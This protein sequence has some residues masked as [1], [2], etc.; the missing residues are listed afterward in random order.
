MDMRIPPLII[1]ILLESNPEVQNLS[2]EIGSRR[3]RVPEALREE[4]VGLVDRHV[5]DVGEGDV[6]GSCLCVSVRVVFVTHCS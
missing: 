6:L 1:K 2:T 4:E 3:P 5:R